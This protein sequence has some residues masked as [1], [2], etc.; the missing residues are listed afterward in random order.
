MHVRQMCEKYLENGKDVYAFMDLQ[1]AY[2]AID[3]HGMW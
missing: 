2:D 3:R 1:K